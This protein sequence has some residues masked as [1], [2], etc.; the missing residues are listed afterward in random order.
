M[1]KLFMLVG[2]PGA[3]K[4]TWIRNQTLT[5]DAIILSTDAYIEDR[6]LAEDK[7]YSEAFADYIYD[8]TAQL[9]EDLEYAMQNGK[10][11]IWD[12]TNLTLRGRRE[13]LDKVMGSYE[14][15]AV[16]FKTPDD[17][18]ERLMKRES[19]GKIIPVSIFTSMKNT[20]EPPTRFEGFSRIIEV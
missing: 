14:K 10:D 9:H 19:T 3:G 2:L 16:V 17:I 4:S 6:A 11:I 18:A 13:K 1:P 8:A 12:Q 5:D 7:T 20:Y 15:I